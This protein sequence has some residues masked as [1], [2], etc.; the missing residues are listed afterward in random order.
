MRLREV[1]S[2]IRLWIQLGVVESR[3]VRLQVWG[4][5]CSLTQRTLHGCH[6]QARQVR[7][8]MPEVRAAREL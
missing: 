1:R 3:V 4:H 7:R 2:R 8:A 6:Q 5:A